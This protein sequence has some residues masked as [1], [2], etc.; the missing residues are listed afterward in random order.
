MA[1]KRKKPSKKYLMN[2][3]DKLWSQAIHQRDR[4]RGCLVCGTQDRLQA[5]H[6][7][8]RAVRATRYK[9]ENGV[10][11][12]ANHHQWCPRLSAHGA[13]LSFAAFVQ[14]KHVEIWRWVQAN[15]NAKCSVTVEWYQAVIEELKAAVNAG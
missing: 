11:L 15:K 13:P 8:G 5:H 10:L 14:E 9:L 2:L 6:L 4:R 3:A 7:I 12:C 1:K